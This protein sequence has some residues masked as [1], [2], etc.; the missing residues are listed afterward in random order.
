MV[1]ETKDSSLKTS[2][3]KLWKAFMAAPDSDTHKRGKV[4]IQSKQHMIEVVEELEK[5]N[6]VMY[7]SEDGNVV[8]I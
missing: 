3:D 7:S 4:I 8:L 5:D 1:S 2:V 6:L